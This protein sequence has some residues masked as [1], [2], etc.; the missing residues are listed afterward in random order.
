MAISVPG[1]G[2]PHKRE[3]DDEL[4][5]AVQA[6]RSAAAQTAESDWETAQSSLIA[7]ANRYFGNI[8]NS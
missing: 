5:S 7:D 8:A 2:V 6:S 4:D 3:F 1:G